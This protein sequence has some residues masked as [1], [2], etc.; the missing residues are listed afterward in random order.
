MLF[1]LVCVA[2]INGEFTAK[3]VPALCDMW[4]RRI[5]AHNELM[6]A[7]VSHHIAH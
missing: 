7:K 2:G 4:T 1:V 3:E 6:F 5:Q